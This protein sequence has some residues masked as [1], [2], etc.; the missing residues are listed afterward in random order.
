MLAI[1]LSDRAGRKVLLILSG[2][3]MGLSNLLLFFNQIGLFGLYFKSSDFLTTAVPVSALSAFYVCFTLGFG[4]IPFV[5]LG[6]I[7]SPQKKAMAVSISVAFIWIWNFVAT[8]SYFSVI[9][10]V[11]YQGLFLFNSVNA[12]L[13]SAIVLIFLPE[14]KNKTL[15]EVQEAFNKKTD[16][17]I[18]N[19]FS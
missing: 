13:S 19:C 8:K 15:A 1:L 16:V 12:F 9:A 7:F 6:E 11:D 18:K 17:S 4:G 5:I 10:L 14:T 3:G 2:V